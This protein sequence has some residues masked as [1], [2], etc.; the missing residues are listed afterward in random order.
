MRFSVTDTGIGIPKEKQELIFKPFIQADGSATRLYGGTGLGL[1]IVGHLVD[2]MSGDLWVESSGTEAGSTFYFTAHLGVHD[3]EAAQDDRLPSQLRHRPVLIVDDNQTTREVLAAMLQHLGFRPITAGSAQEAYAIF[4][5]CHDP[6][7]R[8]DFI[9][10]EA[11]LM[12]SGGFELAKSLKART[13]AAHIP[14]LMMTAT[15]PRQGAIRQ[16]D[17]EIEAFISKPVS[18]SDM[19]TVISH[20]FSSPVP[21]VEENPT[22]QMP[23]EIGRSGHHI[24]IAEDNLVNQRLTLRLLEK[25]GHTVKVANNG[26][27]ALAALDEQLFDLILMDLQMPEMDGLEATTAIRAQESGGQHLPIIAMT[28]HTAQGDRERCLEVGMDDYISK[29]IEP[30]KL[31]AIIDRFMK[32]SWEDGE[33]KTMTSQEYVS[34][35]EDALL[36][37]VDND[38]E[39]VHELVHLFLDDCQQRTASLELALEN[40]DGEQLAQA[41]HTLKGSAGNLC[42]YGVHEAAGRLEAVARL[43]D[44]HQASSLFIELQREMTHL[45]TVLKEVVSQKHEPL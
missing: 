6:A 42:A 36:A 34:F 41:A 2:M 8:F 33:L 1:A 35:D 43:G 11:D 24:L 18:A 15:S 3:T 39:L 45:Q 28:A 37:R 40:R 20:V 7:A 30:Q 31:Y 44:L 23:V 19:V 4:D 25:R 29:P 13:D 27:E 17:I 21:A 5:K 22:P 12:P 14:L 32:R 16:D 38:V 26:Q 10:V 9:M